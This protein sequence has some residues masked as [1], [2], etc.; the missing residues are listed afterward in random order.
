[1]HQIEVTR[2]RGRT[3]GFKDIEAGL[4]LEED[5]DQVALTAIIG[6]NFV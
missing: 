1:L 4:L 2:S 3:E 6:S 5:L